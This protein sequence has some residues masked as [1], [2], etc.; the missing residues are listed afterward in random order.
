MSI[1]FRVFIIVTAILFLIFIV[2][3]VK[4]RRL[5][6]KDS[7]LW[8]LASIVILIV[9]IFPQI[10]DSI[11]GLFG[12]FYPAAILFF[13]GIIFTLFIVGYHSTRLSD[14]TEKNKELAQKIGILENRLKRLEKGK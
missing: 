8:I 2:S 4:K 5:S 12:L 13:V 3:L 7:L 14:L 11:A 10:P 6:E 9:S 1:G